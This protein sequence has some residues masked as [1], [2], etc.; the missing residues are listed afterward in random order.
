MHFASTNFGDIK[1][2]VE[3]KNLDL[4]AFFLLAAVSTLHHYFDGLYLKRG[5]ATFRG[6]E[7]TENPFSFNLDTVKSWVN[8]WLISIQSLIY[9]CSFSG[10]LSIAIRWKVEKG[11]DLLLNG[12]WTFLNVLW[13]KTFPFTV[14]CTTMGNVIQFFS[15][16]FLFLRK[17]SENLGKLLKDFRIQGEPETFLML[18][19]LLP[20][21]IWARFLNYKWAYLSNSEMD[22]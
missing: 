11:F 3:K 22:K 21:K 2:F 15:Y 14:S 8:F 13:S 20:N 17:R 10:L 9:S 7:N 1:T 18:N 12:T 19:F 5:E 6:Y 4:F 16:P